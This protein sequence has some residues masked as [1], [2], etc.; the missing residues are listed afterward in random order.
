MLG[1]RTAGHPIGNLS[2]GNIRSADRGMEGRGKDGKV[3]KKRLSVRE[4]C[5]TWGNYDHA[6]NSRRISSHR[7][8]SPPPQKFAMRRWE[9]DPHTGV[10]QDRLFAPMAGSG[11]PPG[12]GEPKHNKFNKCLQKNGVSNFGQE[13]GKKGKH[14]V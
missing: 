2:P 1:I 3:R 11:P 14:P 13:R 10:P 4:G 6:V 12:S 9:T 5:R 8:F 7:H